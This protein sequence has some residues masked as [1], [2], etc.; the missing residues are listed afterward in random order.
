MPLGFPY[1][2]IDIYEPIGAPK[3]VWTVEELRENIK[4][5]GDRFGLTVYFQKPNRGLYLDIVH[6][7]AKKAD[8][9]IDKD[10]LDIKAEALA[11]AQ[12]ELDDL[13]FYPMVKVGFMYRF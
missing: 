1:I 4:K 13:K 6:E 11:D 12:S 3:T 8:L 9:N 2:S 10:E 5:I 7:L